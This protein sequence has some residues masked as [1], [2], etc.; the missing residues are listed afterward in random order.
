MTQP[1]QSIPLL[2]GILLFATCVH[3]QEDAAIK[4]ASRSAEGWWTQRHEEK[5]AQAKDQKE[6]I[7]I[8][9][10]GDSITQGWEGGPAKPSWDRFYGPRKPINLGFSG[11]RTQHVLWRLDN[12]EV[13]GLRPKAAVLMI[14][15]NNVGG[16]TPEAIAD[17]IKAVVAKIQAKLPETKVLLLAVFPR[18]EKPDDPARAKVQ[19][20]NELVKPL[21]DGKKVVYLDIGP[22]FV[23]EDGTISKE[24]MPD[25][26]HLSGKGYR[27]WAEAIEPTLWTLT[28]N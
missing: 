8:V 2:A 21:H 3:A 15:T 25:F 6:Q 7:G 19:K 16:D 1:P 13:D 12:G 28:E 9:F 10:L 11:D 23:Q 18:G 4:P 22:K 24:I 14:G 17:G 26:L 20:V 27:I 5:L